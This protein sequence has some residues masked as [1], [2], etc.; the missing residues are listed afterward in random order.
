MVYKWYGM[1][2]GRVAWGSYKM[3]LIDRRNQFQS[4]KQARNFI[5]PYRH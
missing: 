3:A 5:D 1:G 4:N 2:W